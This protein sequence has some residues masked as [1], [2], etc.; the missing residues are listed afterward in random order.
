[1]EILEE[2]W[3]ALECRKED[4]ESQMMNAQPGKSPKIE[5]KNWL[6]K[7]EKMKSEIENIKQE[8]DK[9][10]C[11]SRMK[12]G[13]LACEKRQKVEELRQGGDFSDGLVV[14]PP[15]TV[16]H[17]E[18]LSTTT[19][20]GES[21]AKRTKEKIWQHL[22]D[23]DSRKIGVYGMGGIGKTTIMKQIN[24]D[25]LE[26][27]KFDNVIWETVSK[28]FNVIKLQQDIACKLN[29][30][31]SKVS[32]ETTRAS[33][34]NNA[35]EDKK[36]YVLILDDMWEAFRLEEIGIPE[37]TPSNGC[38]LVLTT[39]N[40]DVCRKMD[41]KKIKMEL[42]SGDESRNLFFD[43]VGSNVLNVQDIKPIV[44]EVVKECA[45]LP[46]AIITIAGSLKDVV[47]ASEWEDALYKLRSTKKSPENLDAEIAERLRF[48]YDRL[49]DEKLQRC[50][51]CCALYLEDYEISRDK[52][53]EHLIDEKVI[54]SMK[55]RKAEFNNGHVMLNNLEN[56]C[57][58]GG[59]KDFRTIDILEK[60]RFVKMHDLIREADAKFLVSVYVPKEE[61]WGNDVEKDSLM[62]KRGSKFPNVS[63]KCPKLSTLLLR[64]YVNIIPDSFFV[65]LHGLRVLHV[66]C[67]E[68]ESLPNLVS[69]LKHLT[70]LR[71][72]NSFH[73]RRV[74][75]LAKLTALRSLDLSGGSLEEIPH[76]LEMLVNLRTLMLIVI[77]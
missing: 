59:S 65:H 28:P 11:F 4:I 63:P 60:R 48:S 51:L 35:L 13:K 21:T 10:M 73:I 52:L 42:L 38:K 70:S 66:D 12:L 69:D 46:L 22:L 15:V 45:C 50:L 41:F 24:N 34:L 20:V 2:K 32:D 75:S 47:D 29:L 37:P 61:E 67:L 72:I 57:L 74:P 64:G 27:K 62:C 3:E 31:L 26:E 7:V 56:A 25:L 17:G 33:K 8:A 54:E 55:S 36:R 18:K 40:I 43:T 49:K 23:E 14:D 1:M 58:L 53:I 5:V 6:Q 68:F 44:E 76:G 19:L 77:T 16:S 71:L 39:R 9:R 30:D